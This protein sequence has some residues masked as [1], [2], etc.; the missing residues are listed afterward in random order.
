MCPKCKV[1]TLSP[2]S[3]MSSQWI[4][5]YCGYTEYHS[6]HASIG[7]SASQSVNDAMNRFNDSNSRFND[8]LDEIRRDRRE[9]NAARRS[10]KASQKKDKSGG[11]IGIIIVAIIVY[12]LLN[13]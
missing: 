7:T 12:I 10:N 1:G 5:N 6:T 8:T 11:W 2:I 9:L 4:C 13:G 3:L